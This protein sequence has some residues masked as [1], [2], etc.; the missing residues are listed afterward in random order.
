MP[1]LY[2]RAPGA[3]ELGPWPAASAARCTTRAP[4]SAQLGPRASDQGER[5]RSRVAWAAEQGSRARG[6]VPPRKWGEPSA[7]PPGQGLHSPNEVL[8]LRHT[9]RAKPAPD[10]VLRPVLSPVYNV[11]YSTQ[12]KV[13][14]FYNKLAIRWAFIVSQFVFWVE[15]EAIGVVSK[16]FMAKSEA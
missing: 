5:A 4:T 16:P 12:Q 13:L 7:V 14:F 9:F 11:L 8:Y 10:G 3:A 2:P 15:K 1:G 6:R